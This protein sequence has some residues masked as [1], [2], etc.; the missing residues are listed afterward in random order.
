MDAKRARPGIL[1]LIVTLSAT[2]LA[3]GSAA[4]AKGPAPQVSEA[5]PPVAEQGTVGL[6]VTVKG[7]N[8]DNSAQVRFFVTGTTNPGGV[9]VNNVRFN[10]PTELVANI[11]VD[12]LAVVDNFDIEVEL[13]SNGRKGKGTEKF[14]VLEKGSG[15]TAQEVIY[16]CVEFRNGPD[17]LARSDTLSETYCDSE[18]RKLGIFINK[19]SGEFRMATGRSSRE[20]TLEIPDCPRLIGGDCST[21]ATLISGTEWMDTGFGFEPLSNTLNLDSLEIGETLYV[22]FAFPFPSTSRSTPHVVSFGNSTRGPCGDPL[23]VTRIDLDTWTIEADTEL[24]C[25]EE[26]ISKNNREYTRTDFPVPFHITLRRE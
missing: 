12:D 19:P 25:L 15:G 14:A 16:L 24:A 10:G 4:L 9:T 26:V 2:L 20:I 7:R 22:D 11:D 6:D 17:D 21:P 1:A 3:F 8:F 13:Q 5:D 23:P 18:E